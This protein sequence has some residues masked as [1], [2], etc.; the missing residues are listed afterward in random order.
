M[1]FF[2]C[3]L[4][5]TLWQPFHIGYVNWLQIGRY[6]STSLIRSSQAFFILAC[7]FWLGW[8]RWKLN[9]PTRQ[10][11]NEATDTVTPYPLAARHSREAARHSRG[12]VRQW[13]LIGNSSFYLCAFFFC[14]LFPVL[15]FSHFSKFQLPLSYLCSSHSNFMSLAI[16]TLTACFSWS[17]Q[18]RTCPA[19]NGSTPLH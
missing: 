1:Y 16:G 14:T 17:T 18:K 3:M 8:H 2:G 10:W 13:T 19:M 12:V 4:L 6:F 11:V 15:W 9:G 7:M 5:S